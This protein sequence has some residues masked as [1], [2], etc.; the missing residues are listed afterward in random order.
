M[1]SKVGKGVKDVEGMVSC[2]SCDRGG[3]GSVGECGVLRVEHVSSQ[4]VKYDRK[5]YVF[6]EGL[7]V[8]AGVIVGER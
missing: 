3:F 4:K 6:V 8:G 5:T 1:S 7:G 2:G